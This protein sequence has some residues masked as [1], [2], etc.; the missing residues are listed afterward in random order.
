[1]AEAEVSQSL[2][3]AADDGVGLC[4]DVAHNGNH[5]V[6]RLEDPGVRPEV[7]VLPSGGYLLVADDV[8]HHAL[9]SDAGQR[10]VEVDEV[11]ADGTHIAGQPL[12]AGEYALDD[13]L[14]QSVAILELL[15]VV[16][17]ARTRLG[18]GVP[19]GIL[20]VGGYHAVECGA[21]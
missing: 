9:L 2:T 19:L 15:A 5:V 4:D 12:G 16:L 1:M 7:L 10:G 13:L 20:T 21:R 11:A 18:P 17:E 14:A 6:A 3:V 8:T